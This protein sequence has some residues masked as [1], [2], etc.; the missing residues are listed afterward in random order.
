MEVDFQ[1]EPFAQFRYFLDFA[2]TNSVRE[3]DAMT[4]ATVG[5]DGFPSARVLYMKEL[6]EKGLIFYTN[7]ESQKSKELEENSKV[8]VN[9]FWPEVFIQVRISGTIQKLNREQSVAYFQTRPRISQIGAWASH[10]SQE[11]PNYD[12]LLKRFSE[13]E[14]KFEGLTVPCPE[15]WG[16]YLLMPQEFEFWIGREGRLHERYCYRK[17]HNLSNG[18]VRFMRSP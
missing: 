7:Y 2:K 17:D 5:A 6:S 9:F 13:Y 11:M 14:K 15:E 16:G 4:L 8:C 12:H 3:Y 10:Q 18:W 1:L